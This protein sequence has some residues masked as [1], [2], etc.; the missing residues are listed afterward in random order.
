MSPGAGYGDSLWGTNGGRVTRIWN[1]KYLTGETE[2][3]IDWLSAPYTG[4]NLIY[5]PN[6]D[7]SGVMPRMSAGS[8]ARTRPGSTRFLASRPLQI[9]YPS[10][11]SGR[12]SYCNQIGGGAGKP[13]QLPAV[14]RTQ[15]K[16]G[17]TKKL[18]QR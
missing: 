11:G 7:I 2:G 1:K 14:L 15:I 6:E 16:M 13:I 9:S 18:D 5:P 12:D 10:N 8:A 17:R 3:R 4:R